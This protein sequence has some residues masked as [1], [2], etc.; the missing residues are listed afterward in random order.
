MGLRWYVGGSLP[1]QISLGNHRLVGLRWYVLAGPKVFGKIFKKVAEPL[2][3][4]Y[5]CTDVHV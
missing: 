2:T 5:V 3:A 1:L 4:A